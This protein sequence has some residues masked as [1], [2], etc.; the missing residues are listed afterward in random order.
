M[1]NPYFTYTTPLVAGETARS[2]QVNATEQSQETGFD[3]VYA[4]VNRGMRVP[5]GETPAQAD[6][7]LTE[8]AAA[9]ALK[10]LGF[11]AAGTGYQL[12]P[13]VPVFRGAW[14]TATGYVLGDIVTAGAEQSLYYCLV[15]HTSGVFATDLAAGKWVKIIDNSGAYQAS[16]RPQIITAAASPY[17]ASAGDDLLVDVGAGP[18]TIN[19]PASP[20]L[21]DQPIGIT[22]LDG[23]ITVNNITVGRN[24]KLI[25]ALTQDMT[26]SDTNAS[27]MLGY[28]DA[29]RG[30]RLIRGT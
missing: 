20:A 26:I 13:S 22:H 8:N 6:Y 15:A 7:Q 12:F 16:F 1:S 29:A 30:W 18:V 14:L 21:G 11:N 24:G 2:G 17:L 4:D 3:L 25:M 23:N 27:V 28:S 19:L 5:A 9:R 10:V